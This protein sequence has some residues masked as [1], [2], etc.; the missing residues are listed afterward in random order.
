[1]P[2]WQARGRIR[3]GL[4]WFDSVLTDEVAQDVEVA[5]AIRSRALADKAMIDLL[6]GAADS[7]ERAQQAL[8]LARD[9]DDPAVLAR[10]LTA[11]GLTAAYNA[12]LAGTYFAEAI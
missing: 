3:E 11:C 12:D 2:L 8:A 6:F 10:A 4:T 9:I 5:A 1:Q 7:V